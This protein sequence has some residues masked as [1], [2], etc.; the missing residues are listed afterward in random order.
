MRWFVATVLALSITAPAATA[1]SDTT[2]ILARVQRLFD[3][4]H[5]KDSTAIVTAMDTS[6]ILL[7]H[8][9]RPS[10]EAVVHI[11][12]ARFGGIFASL[13]AERQVAEQIYD[14]EVRID[15][16]LATVW[17]FYVFSVD[18][19]ADHCGVDAFMLMRFAD[20]WRIVSVADT[21]R[22]TDCDRGS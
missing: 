14:P 22:R 12:A 17:A 4:M 15:G 16:D 11:P 21:Q 8:A 2:E 18:G 5:A 1:Q 10:G 6:A 3:A 19:N 9:R 7:V 13:P 20:G